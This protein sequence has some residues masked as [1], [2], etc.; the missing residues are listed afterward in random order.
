M[1]HIWHIGNS[2]RN[3]RRAH[4]CSVHAWLHSIPGAT[5]SSGECIESIRIS[6]V[7]LSSRLRAT[8]LLHKNQ[9]FRCLFERNCPSIDSLGWNRHIEGEGGGCRYGIVASIGWLRSVY[10]SIVRWL[11]WHALT[12]LHFSGYFLDRFNWKPPSWRI[13]LIQYIALCKRNWFTRISGSSKTRIC[14]GYRIDIQR[15]ICG[16]SQT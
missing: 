8:D 13:Q 2:S 5:Q 6:I 3:Q 15:I 4:T 10:S 16:S 9:A 1:L 12:V 14:H 7:A 11:P